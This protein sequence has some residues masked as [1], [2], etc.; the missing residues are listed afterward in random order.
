MDTRKGFSSLLVL[1]LMVLLIVAV[2]MAGC[3]PRLVISPGM[4]DLVVN[5]PSS[6][7]SQTYAAPQGNADAHFVQPDDYFF[8]EESLEDYRWVYVKLGKLS[9]APSPETKNQAQFL[10]TSTGKQEW[11]KWWAKTRIATKND[12]VLGTEVICFDSNNNGEVYLPPVSNQ[13][14]R[15]DSWFLAR[16]TDTSELFKGYVLVTDGYK[17]HM[18][19]LRVIIK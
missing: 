14:A 13:S 18:N 10:N 16:I 2:V 4:P 9:T 1:K 15:T 7:S 3:A 8:N 11:A 12:L 6:G 17:V 19:N 5:V